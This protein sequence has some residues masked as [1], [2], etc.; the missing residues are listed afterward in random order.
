M[1]NS[2]DSVLK[3]IEGHKDAIKRNEALLAANPEAYKQSLKRFA[4]FGYIIYATIFAS[5][6][7][8]AY[9]CYWLFTE[10]A[11]N[12]LTIYFAIFTAVYLYATVTALFIRFKPSFLSIKITPE[13]APELW[14]MVNQLSTQLKAPKINRIYLDF[15][16]N[17][18]ALQWPRF[19]LFGKIENILTIGIPLLMSMD[20]PCVKTV[21]AHEFGH[22]A[23][24]HGKQSGFVYRSAQLFGNLYSTLAASNSWATFFIRSILNAYYPKLEQ[25]SLPVSRIN[26]YEADRVAVSAVGTET[27][28]HMMVKF[29]TLAKWFGTYVMEKAITNLPEQPTAWI[30][31][32]LRNPIPNTIFETELTSSIK[33]STDIESTHPCLND[34]LS[35]Q[36]IAR[37]TEADVTNFAHDYNVRVESTAYETLLNSRV[38]D[39]VR[40]MIDPILLIAQA[41]FKEK[42]PTRQ[43]ASIDSLYQ[44]DIG[45]APPIEYVPKADQSALEQYKDLISKR[46]DLGEASFG[47]AVKNFGD[48]HNDPLASMFCGIAL[49]ETDRP[50]AIQKLESIHMNPTFAIMANQILVALYSEEGNETAAGTHYELSQWVTQWLTYHGANLQYARFYDILPHMLSPMQLEEVKALVAADDRI[51]SAYVCMVQKKRIFRMKYQGNVPIV[52]FDCLTPRQAKWRWTGSVAG[53][54][55]A[56]REHLQEEIST[57]ILPI[58]LAEGTVKWFKRL[59]EPNSALKIK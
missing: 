14:T 56:V 30:A 6:I 26:E 17:A 51:T 58:P 53:Q 20:A 38:H 31:E 8:C 9:A 49:A 46:L 40:A 47:L 55:D 32:A 48:R 27:F 5:A 35:A 1:A 7:A 25:K 13:E 44:Q 45:Q 15:D 43:T 11:I 21:I 34:R 41:D 18:S 19:G 57:M 39:S 59:Q 4:V 24:E 52:F 22:F 2:Y 12:R 23:G 50:Y 33:E 16:M 10:N 42:N 3:G 37:A 29:P 28:R 54:S 36:K